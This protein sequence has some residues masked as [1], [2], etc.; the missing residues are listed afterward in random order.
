MTMQINK[1]TIA[2]FFL[3]AGATVPS[4][5]CGFDEDLV[6]ENM[7]GKVV[8]PAAAATREFLRADGSVDVVEDVRLIGPVYLG[9]YPSVL[10]AEAVERY[11]HPE[12]G[13]QYIA[14]TPGDAYPYGGT[15]IGD[16]RY[17]CFEELACKVTSGRFLDFDALVTWFNDVLEVPIT[18]ASGAQVESGEFIRQTCYQLLDVTSDAEIQITAVDKNEDEK[19]TEIDLDFVKRDDGDYEAEFTL[20]QQEYLKDFALWAFMDSPDPGTAK[21]TTC[22]P[23]EGVNETEYANDFIGG[24][25]NEDVLN[26]PSAYITEGDWVSDGYVWKD[27]FANPELYIDFEVL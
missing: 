11:P 23:S 10:P 6:I 22:N 8:V 24:R 20:W 7:R 26:L 18:D 19:I 16:L 9:L 4:G 5:G 21:F 12:Q 27:V 2:G 14:N 13:P 1:F 3:L 25:V 15:T 17:A